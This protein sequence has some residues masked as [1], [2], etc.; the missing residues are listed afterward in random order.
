MT[1]PRGGLDRTIRVRV[2]DDTFEALSRQALAE[3]LTLA[4][5]LRPLLIKRGQREEKDMTHGR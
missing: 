5:Y 3:G 1:G 2:P 4:A